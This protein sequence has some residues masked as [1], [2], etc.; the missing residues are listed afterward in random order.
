MPRKKIDGEGS[1]STMLRRASNCSLRLRVKPGQASAPANG[2]KGE[3]ANHL[4]YN[5]LPN[6]AAPGQPRQ[7]E[8]GN[9]RYVKGQ[10]V[11]GEA[12]KVWGEQTVNEET[13]EAEEEEAEGGEEE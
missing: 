6:T 10:T 3:P 13:V 12:P 8:A 7:C 4:H 2:G 9:E 1:T 11:I 5:P